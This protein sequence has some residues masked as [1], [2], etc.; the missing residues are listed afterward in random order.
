MEN[1]EEMEEV[2][3]KLEDMTIV[4]DVEEK[5][6]FLLERRNDLKRSGQLMED[7]ERELLLNKAIIMRFLEL[8]NI[9][10]EGVTLNL[11]SLL[12]DELNN[13]EELNYANKKLIGNH[14]LL[15]CTPASELFFAS[16]NTV[17]GGVT[18]DNKL[19]VKNKKERYVHSFTEDGLLH[20]SNYEFNLNNGS[21]CFEDMSL[22]GTCIYSDK[23]EI[24]EKLYSGYETIKEQ[25]SSYGY[26]NEYDRVFPTM[27][28]ISRDLI[29]M[30][31]IEK[32]SPE[33]FNKIE[34]LDETVSKSM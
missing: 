1:I 7:E 33:L 21:I 13:S 32:I 17:S 10:N 27:K 28:G 6:N 20:M 25:S 22:K 14:R 2:N 8:E 26:A 23:R 9:K 11:L 3:K 16:K 30:D 18:K 29:V 19:I 34:S 31:S 15:E 12:R 24:H 5:L 4:H